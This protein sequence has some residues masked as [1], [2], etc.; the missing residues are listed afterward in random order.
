MP[1]QLLI[2]FCR[3]VWS[4]FHVG[5][6]CIASLRWLWALLLLVAFAWIIISLPA[7]GLDATGRTRWFGIVLQLAGFF[8][9][10]LGLLGT[11]REHVLPNAKKWLRDWWN[12]RPGHREPVNLRGESTLTMRSEAR[13]TVLR[14]PNATPDQRLTRLEQDV[15]RLEA[16]LSDQKAQIDSSL[17][18]HQDQLEK[19]RKSR[20]ASQT[21]LGYEIS[22][23][24]RSGLQ[25]EAAGVLLFAVGAV[26]AGAPDDVSGW[27]TG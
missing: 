10:T 24:A 20:E 23:V 25:L 14:N 15:D 2:E 3:K 9:T 22:R 11:A 17:K 7:L 8:L 19:E 16:R 26:L 1:M 21:Q 18:R 5:L 4:Y 6:W 13:A 12:T 27:F